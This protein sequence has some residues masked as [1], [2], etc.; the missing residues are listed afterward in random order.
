[1]EAGMKT[2]L[3]VI[4]SAA[5]LGGCA[6]APVDSYS[7]APYYDAGPYYAPYYAPYYTP[8]YYGPDYY[9]Y[10][11]PVIVGGVR[12]YSHDRHDWR[13][14]QDWRGNHNRSTWR[15]G[16]HNTQRSVRPTT[17]AGPR[18]QHWSGRPAAGSANR[19]T[20]PVIAPTQ[21]AMRPAPETNRLHAGEMTRPAS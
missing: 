13:D 3:A 5:V 10:S 14:R 20:R 11:P 18:A 12:Y 8:G 21:R 7:Y 1:M 17:S 19:T 9:Y 4:A 2:L 16:Q 15:S 6:V